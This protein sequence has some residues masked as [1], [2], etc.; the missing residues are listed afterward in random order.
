MEKSQKHCSF[1][2]SLLFLTMDHKRKDTKIVN[3]SKYAVFNITSKLLQ[4]QGINQ[5]RRKGLKTK[6]K[7]LQ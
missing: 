5:E 1:D 4:S 7:L 2:N 3:R 6:Q